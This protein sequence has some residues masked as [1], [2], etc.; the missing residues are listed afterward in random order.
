M[1]GFCGD[2]GFAGMLETNH[3]V[4]D[5][6]VTIEACNQDLESTQVLTRDLATKGK[7]ALAT[8]S[9]QTSSLAHQTLVERPS[10]LNLELYQQSLA[11]SLDHA[12]SRSCLFRN[13]TDSELPGLTA[14]MLHNLQTFQDLLFELLQSQREAFSVYKTDLCDISREAFDTIPQDSSTNYNHYIRFRKPSETTSECLHSAPHSSN[15]KHHSLPSRNI[16]SEEHSFP[17]QKDNHQLNIPLSLLTISC[18]M[19]LVQVCRKVLVAI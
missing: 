3:V 14:S 18:Y 19:K 11:T 4:P 6:A 1:A 10:T 5:P 7:G 16:T 15:R 8:E 13:G 2:D 12:A 9:L 17:A